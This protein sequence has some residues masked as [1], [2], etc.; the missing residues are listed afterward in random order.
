M[1]ASDINQ[2]NEM[3]GSKSLFVNLSMTTNNTKLS[4]Y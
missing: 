1:V 4:Q 3:S 2:T